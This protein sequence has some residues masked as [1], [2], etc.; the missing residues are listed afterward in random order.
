MN[1]VQDIKYAME[2]LT[3]PIKRQM[4]IR[5]FDFEGKEKVL[6]DIWEIIRIWRVILDKMIYLW[7]ESREE[8]KEIHDL[9]RAEERKLE[10]YR[11][12]CKNEAF[13]MLKVY[14]YSLWD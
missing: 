13:D 6:W 3:I 4:E 7:R 1:T 11:E 5:Y 14:F 8:T 12:Q 2:W 9:H 10:E